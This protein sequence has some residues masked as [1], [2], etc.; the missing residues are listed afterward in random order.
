M[1]LL[2]CC[3]FKIYEK[4]ATPKLIIMH[5]NAPIL[6]SLAPPPPPHHLKWAEFSVPADLDHGK[7]NILN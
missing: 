5:S 1:L 7:L 4:I 2:W 3:P 6:S